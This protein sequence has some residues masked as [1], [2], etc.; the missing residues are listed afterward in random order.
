MHTTILDTL[1][2]HNDLRQEL[3][4]ILTHP[5][6]DWAPGDFD[7]PNEQSIQSCLETTPR[8]LQPSHELQ[9]R[10]PSIMSSW[11]PLP[12]VDHSAGLQIFNGYHG[13]NHIPSSPSLPVLAP[14][15][16]PS[17]YNHAW[18]NHDAKVTHTPVDDNRVVPPPI[19]VAF[20]NPWDDASYADTWTNDGMNFPDDGTYVDEHSEPQESLALLYGN[21]L[22]P[23]F[24]YSQDVD[25][26]PKPTHTQQEA[27]QP[28]QTAQHTYD[29]L[30]LPETHDRCL[31]TAVEEQQP[32]D[33]EAS[34]PPVFQ[35][36][37]DVQRGEDSEDVAQGTAKNQR[38]SLGGSYVHILCGKSF[39][40]LSKVKKHH[41]GK[42]H[43]D[44]AATTGCWAKHNKP[45]IAWDADPSCKG[46][47][48]TSKMCKPVLSMSTQD[49]P[50]AIIPQAKTPV[51]FD[52]PQHNTILGFP[53]LDDL[54]HTVAKTLSASN[55]TT[56]GPHDQ[57][58]LYHNHQLPSRS[59]FDSLLT[60]VNV[61]SQIDAPKARGR[62]DSIAMH[63]DAQVTA[64]EGPGQQVF[65]PPFL[66]LTGSFDTRYSRILVPTTHDT[67]GP[68]NGVS[69]PYNTSVL[70]HRH[71]SAE[72]SSAVSSDVEEVNEAAALSRPF[73]PVE[74]RS[75]GPARKK[76][77][78]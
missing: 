58:Q 39:A 6:A 8:F 43:N 34:P 56:P 13:D 37:P 35:A 25:F 32:V 78:V 20:R 66:H 61:V 49:T 4:D 51:T 71:G 52:V 64:A 41:W 17:P 14:F 57:E 76:R 60:A 67:D 1:E 7:L 59:N 48:S 15:Q 55:A 45:D 12:Q 21:K 53:T 28:M 22:Q 33:I 23:S 44:L 47:R 75:S 16:L 40:T 3:M 72:P 11:F 54:P 70:H 29:L 5:A 68:D 27:L 26:H 19:H 30:P 18:L 10:L 46:G 42:K 2:G 63:L 36:S 73:T 24:T 31:V 77:K 74:A 65:Y 69:S 62:T 38:D 9:I 50:K